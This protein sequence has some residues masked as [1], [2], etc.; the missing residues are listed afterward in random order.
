MRTHVVRGGA[1][2]KEREN[3]KKKG[4]AVRVP[5]GGSDFAHCYCNFLAGCSFWGVPRAT[6]VLPTD[7]CLFECHRGLLYASLLAP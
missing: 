5:A 7:G 2:G 4:N 6:G 1:K 3:E